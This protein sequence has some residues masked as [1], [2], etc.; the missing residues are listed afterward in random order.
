[1][2]K[3]SKSEKKASNRCYAYQGF[4]LNVLDIHLLSLLGKASLILVIVS[5]HSS[6]ILANLAFRHAKASSG[7][8][9]ELSSFISQLSI[10]ICS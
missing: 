9:V 10:I 8:V 5:L 6:D 3:K 2:K 4:F 1:M 7:F